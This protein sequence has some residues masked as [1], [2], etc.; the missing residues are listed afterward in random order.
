[1]PIAPNILPTHISLFADRVAVF[2][3]GFT[4][5]FQNARPMKAKVNETSELFDHPVE[6]GQRN[7]DYAI[8]DPIEIELPMIVESF[9][10][11]ATYQQIKQ[12]YITKEL[13]TVQTNTA[14]YPN[15]V[16]ARMP[17]DEEP[18]KFD[19]LQITLHFREKQL[20]PDPSTFVPA[21][22]TW[23]DTAALGQQNGYTI[24]NTVTGDI[25][26]VPPGGIA[27][28]SVPPSTGTISGV[29][30]LNGPQTIPIATAQSIP[31]TGVQTVTTQ[32]SIGSVFF[33]GVPIG[34]AH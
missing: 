27:Y 4:Q 14:N 5:V 28:S 26:N 18:D 11:R 24:T 1:M 9:F 3:S 8:I 13:L 30:G 2:D 23:A 31:V 21:E 19:A 22:P 32:Q 33:G 20:V 12:L 25:T 10:Y 16:I 17:H 6:S 29:A 34:S 15:M 7:T